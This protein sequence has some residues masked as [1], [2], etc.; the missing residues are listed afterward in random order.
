[1]TTTPVT[2]TYTFDAYLTLD[3][4]QRSELV[5]GNLIEINVEDVLAVGEVG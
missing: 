1:M 4:E 3:H 5:D 2:Q